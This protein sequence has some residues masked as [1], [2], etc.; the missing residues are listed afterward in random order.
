[1]KTSI[2]DIA[3]EAGVSDTAVSLAFKGSSRI[4]E[5]TR[6]KIF[7]T[8]KRLRYVPN[9]AAQNLRSGKTNTIGFIVNDISNPFYSLMIKEA[10][11]KLNRGEKVN[12]EEFQLMLG[13]GEDDNSETQA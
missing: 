9:S 1:M 12:W 13:N 4:T 8:A 7:A 11:E 10:E 5:Q 2:K 3:R 6:E